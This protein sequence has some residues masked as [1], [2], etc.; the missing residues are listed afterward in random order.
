MIRDL[1]IDND[2]VNEMLR[3]IEY[4]IVKERSNKKKAIAISALNTYY[5]CFNVVIYEYLKHE[6]G[7]EDEIAADESISYT[8]RYMR[9]KGYIQ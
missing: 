7:L 1:N 4:G 8:D 9:S 2:M 5:R 3:D 6:R